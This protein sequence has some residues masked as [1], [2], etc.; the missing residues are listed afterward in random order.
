MCYD[1]F[2][3]VKAP[4]NDP[5]P[6]SIIRGREAEEAFPAPFFLGGFKND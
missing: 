4:D 2:I 6:F 1:V 3:K 5:V